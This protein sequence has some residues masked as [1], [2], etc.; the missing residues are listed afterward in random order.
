P[1][2]ASV[3]ESLFQAETWTWETCPGMIN[4]QRAVDKL[5]KFLPG[6]G[7]QAIIRTLYA[8]GC[9]NAH[10]ASPISGAYPGL[11]QGAE[12]APQ[13]ARDPLAVAS[14]RIKVGNFSGAY[15]EFSTG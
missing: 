8:P 15:P 12:N 7:K 13:S 5:L 6:C 9:L 14:I 3:W 4:P 10:K 2:R 11:Y 1:S